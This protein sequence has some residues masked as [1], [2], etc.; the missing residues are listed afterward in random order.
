ML[1][2]I[3]SNAAPHAFG[4]KTRNVEKVLTPNRII[5]TFF[6]TFCR[7]GANKLLVPICALFL[8]P[9]CKFC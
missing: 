4:L 2:A 6:E 3:L 9:T 1:S 7:Q 5:E 8:L